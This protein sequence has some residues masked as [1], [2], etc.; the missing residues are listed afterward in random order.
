MKNQQK[1]LVFSTCPDRVVAE[2]LAEQLVAQQ[3]AACVNVLPGLTS[4]YRWQ[5]KIERDSEVLLL[6]K[7]DAAHY[8][9]LETMIRQHH[10]YE[11]PEIIGVS[12]EMGLPDYLRWITTSLK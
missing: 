11:L 7:T 8:S 4:V 3:L 1:L 2:S 10:P 12:V 9:A 6:I 5:G